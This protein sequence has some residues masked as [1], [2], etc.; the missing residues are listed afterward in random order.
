MTLLAKS[1]HSVV[2]WFDWCKSGG[3]LPRD[4]DAA[5]FSGHHG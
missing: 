4:A 2:L 1:V 5:V 3:T